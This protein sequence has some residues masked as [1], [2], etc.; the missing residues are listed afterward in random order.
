MN[1][2]DSERMAESL[3]R[4]G[5][6][7]TDDADQADLVV[8]NTCHI[9]EKAAEKVYSDLGRLRLADG[10]GR[11]RYVVAGC[12][13]QA[14]GDEILRRAPQVDAVFGPQ[15][16][17][18]LPEL[19]ARWDD[20]DAPAGAAGGHRLPGGEQVR[21]PARPAGGLHCQRLPHGAG[22][23]RQVLHLLRRALHPGRRS[24]APGG[25]RG[26]RGAA[27]WSPAAPVRSPCS[28]RTSTPITAPHPTAGSGR[29]AG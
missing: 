27:H 12:V 19:V 17:H 2:Y 9:R 6:E 16:Y 18:R 25:G 3:A 26:R 4:A 13:A 5:Y 8:L 21:P 1:V 14:E 24:L 29:S 11:R 7:P 22:G 15:T 10:A 23:L 28:A 20:G